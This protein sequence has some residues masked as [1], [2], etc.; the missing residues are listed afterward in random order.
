MLILVSYR[1]Q[2]S[3]NLD[4]VIRHR[5]EAVIGFHRDVPARRRASK[6]TAWGQFRQHSSLQTAEY[7]ERW[8]DRAAGGAP[9]LPFIGIDRASFNST[10]SAGRG[11]SKAAR[12]AGRYI[13]GWAYLL[14]W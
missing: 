1:G 14:K 4:S 11:T 10:R 2:R 9:G 12:A 8:G 5:G 6:P 13:S 7:V 3:P